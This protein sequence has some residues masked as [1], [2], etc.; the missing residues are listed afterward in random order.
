MSEPAIT[1]NLDKSR[2]EATDGQELVGFAE[3]ITTDDLLVFTHT[4]VFREGQGIGGQ[5]ARAALDAVRAEGTR[6]V[7]PQCPFIKAWINK[8]PE[9]ADLVY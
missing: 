2:W 1:N 4:E 8:N 3:Y 5:L 7:M 6:K 9:Y